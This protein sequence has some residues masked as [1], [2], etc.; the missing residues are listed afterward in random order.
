MHYW[1]FWRNEKK[2]TAG[3]PVTPSEETNIKHDPQRPHMPPLEMAQPDDTSHN[4]KLGETIPEERANQNAPPSLAAMFQQGN[5]EAA[6]RNIR[7]GRG[8]RPALQ[9]DENPTEMLSPERTNSMPSQASTPFPEESKSNPSENN[10]KYSKMNRHLNSVPAS[11]EQWWQCFI[12]TPNPIDINQTSLTNPIA[13]QNEQENPVSERNRG[14]LSTAPAPSNLYM[15][16]KHPKSGHDAVRKVVK[17]PLSPPESP[18]KDDSRKSSLEKGSNTETNDFNFGIN[19]EGH[20]YYAEPDLINPNEGQHNAA[21]TQNTQSSLV[22]E[23][24]SVHGATTIQSSKLHGNATH[25]SGKRPPNWPRKKSISRQILRNSDHG[26]V[27]S[28]P[29]ITRENKINLGE[30]QRSATPTPHHSGRISIMPI[31]NNSV[32][33]LETEA[34]QSHSK[35]AIHR[36]KPPNDT[37][38]HVLPSYNNMSVVL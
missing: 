29:D 5:Y 19:G 36:T 11:N 28:R 18:S 26:L 16:T 6:M 21:P 7:K 22:F 31:K 25:I 34:S 9:E 30:R 3:S 12:N 38:A 23:K 10:Y 17:Y 13:R 4:A 32:N 15:S 24:T 2:D 33:A 14:Q 35:L 1:P 27:Y 37:S 8:Q 20:H